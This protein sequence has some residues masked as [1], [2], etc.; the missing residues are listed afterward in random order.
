[1]AE[2]TP[3]LFLEADL[4]VQLNGQPGPL[5]FALRLDANVIEATA[6]A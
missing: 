3:T 6:E 2:D 5:T 4:E 1:M